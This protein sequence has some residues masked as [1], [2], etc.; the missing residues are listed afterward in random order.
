M[1]EIGPDIERA[2]SLLNDGKLVGI[3]TETVYGLAGNAFNK[4]AVIDIFEVKNRPEFDPLIVHTHSVNQLDKFVSEI[5][6]V[7]EKL[8]NRYWPGPMT[9]LLHKKSIIPDIVTSGMERV[10]V[11]IPAHPMTL[12]LLKKLDFPLVAPSANP[13]GYVSPT[14]PGH[15]NDQLGDK[16]PYILDGGKCE[17]GL[18]STI[19][20]LE[21]G[22]AF[23]YRLG[24][25]E[26]E[27]I[28]SVVGPVKIQKHSSSDPKAPGML[29]SHYAPSKKV[30]CGDVTS[31]NHQFKD[32]KKGFILLNDHSELIEGE[33]TIYLSKNGDL[34]EAA[35]GL[36]SSLRKLDSLDIDIIIA[37]EAPDQGLGR[38]IN[39][40]LKRASA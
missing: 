16:I 2:A 6:L 23:V 31:L 4:D 22:E 39:D 40:R 11:R 9:V 28:E 35:R 17:I 5:P 14:T 30:I 13:F 18:E 7:L 1:A 38:A 25:L 32:L 12:E 37:Q 26:L 21:D 24:G 27:Q 8:I 20:G 36:F 29:K 15:V 34:H 10:A 19:V 3:P 33:Q